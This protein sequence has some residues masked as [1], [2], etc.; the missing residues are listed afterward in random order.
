MVNSRVLFRH[1]SVQSE[2]TRFV[3]RVSWVN[4]GRQFPLYFSIY[5]TVTGS[6]YISAQT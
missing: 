5:A 1:I 2:Q 3:I 6:H 4:P